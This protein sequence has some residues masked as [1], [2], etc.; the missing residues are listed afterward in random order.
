MTDTCCV[1]ASREPSE[2]V[3][4]Q[5]VSICIY[6]FFQYVYSLFFDSVCITCVTKFLLLCNNFLPALILRHDRACVIE[7]SKRKLVTWLEWM[8]G[9]VP[10]RIYSDTQCSTTNRKHVKR[11]G[12]KGRGT[13][14]KK[15]EYN[16]PIFFSSAYRFDVAYI[17]YQRLFTQRIFHNVSNRIKSN[18]RMFPS[19][20][21]YYL[22]IINI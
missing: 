1:A 15:R 22:S 11:V 17:F 9:N 4:T 2:P 5:L 8:R 3:R 14:K 10:A 16:S 7:F 19:S 20:N 13:I 18:G 12:E 6:V 21:N